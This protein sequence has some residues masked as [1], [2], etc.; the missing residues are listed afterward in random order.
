MPVLATDAPAFGA[1]ILRNALITAIG[2]AVA[3]CVA[4]ID[5]RRYGSRSWLLYVIATALLVAVL[6]PGI[7]SSNGPS[8]WLDISILS[9]QPSEIAKPALILVLS[10]WAGQAATQIHERRTFLTGLLI[11]G[12]PPVSYTHLTLPTILLV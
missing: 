6:I 12:I 1:A 5:Y 8:R 4:Q 9:F 7:A 11:A 10:Y 3:L 2:I